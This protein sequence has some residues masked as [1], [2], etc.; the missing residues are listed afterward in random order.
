MGNSLPEAGEAI[1]GQTPA[2]VPGGRVGGKGVGG[3][4]GH[5]G[6]GDGKKET[7]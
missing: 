5:P 7:L 4:M 1:D 3:T 2:P 6:N